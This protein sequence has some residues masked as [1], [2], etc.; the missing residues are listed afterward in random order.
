MIGRAGRLKNGK[1]NGVQALENKR[2]REIP[3]SAILMI[4]MT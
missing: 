3:G 4:S 2:F 1:T